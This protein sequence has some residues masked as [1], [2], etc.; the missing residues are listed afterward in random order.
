[1]SNLRRVE[2]IA[3]ELRQEPY[4]LFRYDCVWKSI[5]FKR[6]CRAVGI[7]AR[8]VLCIGRVRAKWFGHWL[9]ILVIHGWGE[10]EGRRIEVSRPL[11]TSGI[12]GM[13]PVSVEPVVGIWI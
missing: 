13:V 12:W 6:R 3:E 4:V 5:E 2:R 1:M 7:P 8:V 9:T 10:V 11:G